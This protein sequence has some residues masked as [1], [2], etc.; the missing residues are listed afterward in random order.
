[1]T[2]RGVLGVGCSALAFGD[3]PRVSAWLADQ[4]LEPWTRKEPAD[5]AAMLAQDARWRERLRDEFSQEK[6]VVAGGLTT[7]MSR[8]IS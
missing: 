1:M 5:A 7:G 2:P 4:G 6:L 8:E 3:Q